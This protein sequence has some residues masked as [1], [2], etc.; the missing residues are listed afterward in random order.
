MIISLFHIFR[1]LMYEKYGNYTFDD[2]VNRLHYTNTQ[3]MWAW[4]NQSKGNNYIGKY[5]Y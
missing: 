1:T 5:K 2:T 3:P 4:Q